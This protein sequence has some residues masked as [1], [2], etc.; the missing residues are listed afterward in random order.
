VVYLWRA[1]KLIASQ[2]VFRAKVKCMVVN[3]DRLYCGGGGGGLKVL[4]AR[5]LTIVQQ[6]QLTPLASAPS[7]TGAT[8]GSRGGSSSG[9]RPR[10][11][12][13]GP[14]TRLAHRAGA[15]H[16]IRPQRAPLAAPKKRN[17]A[18]TSHAAGQN[19]HPAQESAGD[20][21]MGRGMRDPDA[22]GAAGTAGEDD[23]LGAKLVTGL[24]VVRGHGRVAA[25]STYV[26]ASLGTGKLV[27]V[28]VG[29]AS[30]AGSSGSGMGTPRSATG[31]PGSR[32][33]T[34]GAGAG[35]AA[36]GD[37]VSGKDLFHYHT[38]PVYG[39]A[40]DVT[41]SNRL[42]VTVCDDRKLMVWDAQDAVLLAKTATKTAS[43]CCHVDK[44]NSFIAVGSAAGTLTV[45]YLSDQLLPRS[46]YYKVT[47]V[48]FRKDAR[49]EVTEVKFSPSNERIAMGCRD[50]CIYVYNCELGTVPT[51]HGRNMSETGVCILRAMH[52]L[53]G[54]SSSITHLD[55]S[56]DSLLIRS[57]CAAY[58]LL[59][60]DVEAGKQAPTVNVADVKW[61]TQHCILGFTVM[62]IWPP[63]TDGT[64]INALD[65]CPKQ[66]LVAT[67][68]DQGGIVKLHN[69]PCVVRNAPGKEYTGHSS[70]V[71]NLKFMRDGEL[72]MTAGGND[73]SLVI[74]ELVRDESLNDADGFR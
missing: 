48:G 36:G 52:K 26:I 64:D 27:R 28:E 43:R 19:P 37:M 11:A 20:A 47:E 50:D 38:G 71:M 55:W 17:P 61:K 59:C 34:A 21:V 51:G 8:P 3:A 73:R 46:R 66:G 67:A 6:F 63:Y 68:N 10:S 44:T 70:H 32:P 18:D 1:G 40:A 25:Q 16:A 60:W 58:E 29:H 13:A 31:R 42:V 33:G 72:M 49:A 54:H 15:G 2:Q 5:T 22:E 7:G 39:L 9:A 45:Y 56:F 69:Y 4:D 35:G 24:A 74:W 23:G 65:V 57:T 62:G 12:S 30:G 14:A 53:K 41:Q